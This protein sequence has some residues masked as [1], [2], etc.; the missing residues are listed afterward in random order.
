MH[1]LALL[2]LVAIGESGACGY[3]HHER[4]EPT[5]VDASWFRDARADSDLPWDGGGPGDGALDPRD[6][7]TDGAIWDANIDA[8]P[9]P[10][11]LVPD[12]YPTLQAALDDPSCDPIR[13]RGTAWLLETAQLRRDVT[14][15]SVS[16][17]AAATLQGA[18]LGSVLFI[19]SLTH[20]RLE[21][22]AV[23]G[24]L[25][26]EGGGI[27]SQGH[28]TLRHTWIGNNRTSRTDTTTRF[29][30]RGAGIFQSGGSITLE[31]E[32]IFANN[33]CDGEDG[34]A[35]GGAMYLENT[36]LVST[37]MLVL[38]DNLVTSTMGA[39]GG[40]V[41]SMRSDVRAENI[42]VHDNEAAST[43]VS[44]FASGGAF[45]IE[46]GQ[47]SLQNLDIADNTA[48][49][50]SL[51]DGY[52]QTE[53]GAVFCQNSGVITL[54]DGTAINNQAIA[55]GSNATQPAVSLGGFITTVTC[56]VT[57]RDMDIS[58]NHANA[59]ANNSHAAADGGAVSCI[60]AAPFLIDNVTLSNNSAHILLS[61]ATP[62]DGQVSF[63]RGGAISADGCDLSLAH[64]LL[65]QNRAEIEA[66]EQ[67]GDNDIACGGGLAVQGDTYAATTTDVQ[68]T[69]FLRN[70][71]T[72][73]PNNSTVTVQGG[74]ICVTGRPTRGLTLNVTNA[75]LAANSAHVDPDGPNASATGG[76]IDVTLIDPTFVNVGLFNVTV[77]G[78]HAIARHP[79]GSGV[80]KQYS[81]D[82]MRARNS[83]I[84]GNPSEP[85][86]DTV[87]C[88]NGPISDG[89]NFLAPSCSW[90]FNNA[91][92]AEDP[93]LQPL[94]SCG[95]R[96]RIHPLNGSSAAIDVG[97][98]NGCTGPD[99]QALTVD[100]RGEPRVGRCDVGAFEL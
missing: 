78:N 26:Q 27:F 32:N 48:R 33:H 76:G 96:C 80:H 85:G 66:L 3:L 42:R 40:A 64:A 95:D 62:P 30:G 25:A 12:E 63:A 100:Q 77:T 93:G 69:T 98:P 91:D 73:T 28:L 16:P 9:S 67:R 74:G 49:A 59:N 81:P 2:V 60:G 94:T 6:A 36:S 18:G 58:D 23:T 35:S 8:G 24:G 54:T 61:G 68:R 92:H 34:P 1:A 38:Q 90:I 65:E 89:N 41:T 44:P 37:G 14:I 19:D 99:G 21:H 11:C 72:A 51:G 7:T 57:V 17:E 5:D 45:Q 87:D 10:G 71:A 15:T 13:V 4:P 75:T 20:V 56:T 50:E 83:I 86:F 97:N 82:L 46:G 84:W 88:V 39:S 31:G 55:L 43:G 70:E 79:L 29:G 22:L 53:G 52:A 47:W